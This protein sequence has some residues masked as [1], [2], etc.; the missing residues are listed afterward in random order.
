MSS[1]TIHNQPTRIAFLV[2]LPEGVSPGQRFRCENWFP[3]LRE[4]NFRFDYFPFFDPEAYRILYRPGNGLRKMAGTL[5]GFWR[6]LRLLPALRHYDVVFIQREAAPI[7][8]PLLEWFISKCLRRRIIFDFDDAIWIPQQSNP[9]MAALKCY[10]KVKY[11][12]RWSHKVAAGNAYLAAYARRFNTNTIL[13]PT[14]VDTQRQHNRRKEH[15]ATALPVVGWT[16]SHSTL[17]YLEMLMPVLEQVYYKIP[18]QLLVIADRPPARAFPNMQFL[19]WKAA[20]EI[21]DLLRMD[22]G[23]MPLEADAWS[24]GKCGFKIIQYLALGIPALASAVGVNRAIISEKQNGFLCE[25]EEAWTR[26]LQLLVES[27]SLR[28]ALG[29]SGQQTIISHYSITSQ[30]DVFLALFHQ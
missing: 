23:I 1:E 19:P 10:W 25:N 9:L 18:F 28:A 8:P 15:S 16:G 2:Q 5:R 17:K 11:I 3:Y 13:L 4:Q 21:E 22:I 14:V 30:Q 6:R 7:G 12:I 27:A 26:S 29:R 24:E 20:T